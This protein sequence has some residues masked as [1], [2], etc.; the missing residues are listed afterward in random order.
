M[1]E[2]TIYAGGCTCLLSKL[3]M[4]SEKGRLII[5]MPPSHIQDVDWFML[6]DSTQPS[7]NRGAFGQH[8]L[9]RQY[10]NFEHTAR[11]SNPPLQDATQ[12]PLGFLHSQ[13]FETTFPPQRAMHLS[14]SQNGTFLRLDESSR[15]Q[16]P[17]FSPAPDDAA[18]AYIA[19][20]HRPVFQT[21]QQAPVLQQ[22][23]AF[24]ARSDDCFYS[25]VGQSGSQATF[26]PANLFTNTNSH[27]GMSPSQQANQMTTKEAQLLSSETQARQ[28]SISTSLATLEQR[29]GLQSVLSTERPDAGARKRSLQE[30]RIRGGTNEEYS[31]DGEYTP[32]RMRQAANMPTSNAQSSAQAQDDGEYSE[33]EADHPLVFESIDHARENQYFLEQLSQKTIRRDDYEKIETDPEL[34]RTWVRRIMRAFDQNFQQYPGGE[35]NKSQAEVDEWTRFQDDSIKQI[36]DLLKKKSTNAHVKEMTAWKIL[37][38]ILKGHKRGLRKTGTYTVKKS[39]TASERLASCVTAISNIPRV[40]LDVLKGLSIHEFV[41]HPEA[42]ARR[43]CSNLWT[44][45]HRGLKKVETPNT[46]DNTD[47]RTTQGDAHQDQQSGEVESE[48]HET[49]ADDSTKDVEGTES[50]QDGEFT[51]DPRTS[52]FRREQ[53][54]ESYGG[55]EASAGD[56]LN[57]GDIAVEGFEDAEYIDDPRTSIYRGEQGYEDTEEDHLPPLLRSM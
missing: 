33:D 52:I 44:N 31:N 51:D 54:P 32:K 38:A 57:D 14:A 10:F 29:F 18:E 8:S 2:K 11:G 13:H 6:D 42:F 21:Y 12:R 49:G 4:N 37:H 23:A 26:P 24:P 19:Q 46:D 22:F 1:F 50:V 16:L 15:T 36:D 3:T 34:Q 25:T 41:A 45:Y 35:H 47:K 7:I 20:L 48:V 55:Q 30:I 28:A 9:D 17:S 53:M 43:K 40:R 5:N 56:I 39:A 27:F